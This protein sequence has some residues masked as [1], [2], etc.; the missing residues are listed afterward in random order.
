MVI[1]EGVIKDSMLNG[2]NIEDNS[3][4]IRVK[5]KNTENNDLMLF[6]LISFLIPFIMAIPLYLAKEK[7][8]DT[9]IYAILW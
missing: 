1:S 7:G 3:N 4:D 5:S 2:V 8:L 9:S 6:M